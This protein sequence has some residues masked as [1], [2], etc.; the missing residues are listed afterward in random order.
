MHEPAACSDLPAQQASLHEAAEVT[1]VKGTLPSSRPSSS[2]DARIALAN[3]VRRCN[4]GSCF[5]S[6]PR[7]RG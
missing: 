1:M 3:G 7:Q 5:T 2:P 6:I 4:F